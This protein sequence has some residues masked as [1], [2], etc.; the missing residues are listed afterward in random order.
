MEL[1]AL[2]TAENHLECS[3]WPG[4]LVHAGVASCGKADVFL[5]ASHITPEKISQ[6]GY[7]LCIAP[8]IGKGTPRTHE[9]N[10]AKH[11]TNEP[12]MLAAWCTV[13]QETS[14]YGSLSCTG[15]CDLPGLA[16]SRLIPS[17]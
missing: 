2:K 16:T 3:G 13:Q 7:S 12:M 8:T 10:G 1:A 15:L 9:V 5:K 17:H 11:R 14:S 6:L 4:E